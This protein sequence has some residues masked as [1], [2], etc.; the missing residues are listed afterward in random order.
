M[1]PRL[2][3]VA[4]V[5]TLAAGPAHAQIASQGTVRGVVR[6]SEGGVLPGVTVMATSPTDP[7]RHMAPWGLT[8]SRNLN[9]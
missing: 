4:L 1:R 3:G 5:A 2:K 9:I 8:L 7:G 6:D